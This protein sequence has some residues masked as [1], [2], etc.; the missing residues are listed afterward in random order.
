MVRDRMSRVL[1]VMDRTMLKWARIPI[2]GGGIPS[3]WLR[4]SRKRGL[5]NVGDVLSACG[6]NPFGRPSRCLR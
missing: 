2:L 3:R 6:V 4:R 1:H 5:W